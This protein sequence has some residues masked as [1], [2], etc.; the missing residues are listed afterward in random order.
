[1]EPST[2]HRESKPRR[3]RRVLMIAAAFPPMG[4]SGVQRTV[5]FAKYLPKF[6]WLPTI[7]SCKPDQSWPRDESLLLDLPS[8]VVIHRHATDGVVGSARRLSRRMANRGGLSARFGAAIDWRLERWLGQRHAL[9]SFVPWARG[10]VTV[11]QGLIEREKIDVIY[12][13]FSPASNHW[14]ALKMKRITGL[15]WVADFRDLWTDDYRYTESVPQRQ[16]AHRALEQEILEEAD[17]V[18]GVTERQT[19]VLARHVPDQGQKF[20]TITNGFDADDFARVA[21]PKPVKKGR[22]VLAHVGRFDQW[23]TND[24]WYTGLAHFIDSLGD[25]RDRFVMR[26]V[27]HAAPSTLEKVRATRSPCEFTGYVT[28]GTALE[29]MLAADVLLLSVPGGPN[30]ASVIPA[31]LFEYLA[32]RRP[33]LVVGPTGGICEPIVRECQ[34]GVCVNFD[35][36]SI[37]DALKNLFARWTCGEL[38]LQKTDEAALSRYSRESLAGGLSELLERVTLLQRDT[39]ASTNERMVGTLTE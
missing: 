34:A 24:S 18:V 38:E 8:E 31:K 37:A 36:Q 2:R 14:L 25:G 23:R 10:S 27:G 39:P 21:Q 33:I 29:E 9:D 20:I 3:P 7:W 30:A 28:H 19:Q 22:F 17:I 13:T 15:P 32:A 12:S 26:I 1:M 35:A 16:H 6:G 5:K 11:L 4:G